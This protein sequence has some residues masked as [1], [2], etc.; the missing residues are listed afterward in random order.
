[1]H[2]LDADDAPLGPVTEVLDT[3]FMIGRASGDARRIPFEAVRAVMHDRVYLS[4]RA[5]D[6]ERFGIGREV[7]GQGR[8][9]RPATLESAR[10]ERRLR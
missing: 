5:E 3:A 4:L 6:V 2:V 8:T 9:R 10:A 1:M 7:P